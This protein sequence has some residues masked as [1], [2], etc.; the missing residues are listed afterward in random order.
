MTYEVTAVKVP[1]RV[2]DALR[3]GIMLGEQGYKYVTG[4]CGGYAIFCK[5]EIGTSVSVDVAIV[6]LV[7][8]I[9][10]V[11]EGNTEVDRESNTV[12]NT[13]TGIVF[14]YTPYYEGVI[15]ADD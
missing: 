11:L 7:S 14:H 15:R 9:E 3:I 5:D 12:T 6:S 4:F 13:E 8:G 10:Y 1:H 2:P